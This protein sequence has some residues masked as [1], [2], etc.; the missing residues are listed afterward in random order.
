MTRALQLTFIAVFA[1]V[2]AGCSLLPDRPEIETPAERLGEAYATIQALAG[3]AEDAVASGAITADQAEDV[4]DRLDEADRL[5]DRAAQVIA[6]DGTP[7]Q[8]LQALLDLL[9][10]IEQRLEAEQ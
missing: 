5:A 7:D 3:T 4:A 1:V 10:D 6:A 8:Q 2:L 9:A